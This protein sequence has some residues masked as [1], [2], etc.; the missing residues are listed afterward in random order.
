ML[1]ELKVK[2]YALIKNLVFR[3]G[4][5]FN[6]ITGETGAGKSVLLG[7][8]G[9]VLGER[10]DSVAL[11]ENEEKCVVEAW[12]DIRRYPLKSWFEQNEFD[13]SDELILRREIS[14][15]GKSRAF[16]N[17]TPAQLSQLKDLSKTL[18]DIHSQY[19]SL[20]LFQKSFQ[21]GVLDS[22]S[23]T[24][25]QLE[26]YQKQF[27]RYKELRLI[28]ADLKQKQSGG[29]S[30]RAFQEH[31]A[32]ELRTARV[33]EGEFEQ[34][35]EEQAALS[36]VEDTTHALEWVRQVLGTSEGSIVNQFALLRAQIAQAVRNDRRLEDLKERIESQY[37]EAKDL[38]HEADRLGA[39][40]QS[41][42]GRLDWVNQRLSLL[43]Q[44][45]QKH[46]TTDLS[47]KLREI[48]HSLDQYANMS[49]E[50]ESHEQ[51]LNEISA[52]CFKTAGEIA[53]ERKAHCQLLESKIN[54]M[55]SSLGMPGATIR[56]D[57][58][59]N[60]ELGTFGINDVNILFSP[61]RG[62]GFN[63]IQEIAS[64][65]E[66]SRVMLVLKVLLAEKNILPT[67]V[68]DEIDT[69]VSGEIALQMGKMLEEL[70]QRIQLL[71]I[72]HLPQI[73]SKGKRHFFV[74]KKQSSETTVTDITELSSESRVNEIAEMIGGK[75]YGPSILESARHLLN[76]Q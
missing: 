59:T 72:T 69:G 12:F 15:G 34:L 3:P 21:F 19:D 54:T 75:G 23:G 32:D 43:Y 74:F 16:I 71:V 24:D 44:L 5:S 18:I 13:Y 27:S 31:V 48:E 76:P 70:S 60:D 11:R 10:S 7:A 1:T 47:G 2:N 62:K 33:M 26:L 61:A 22:F 40:I 58:T 53:G 4:A 29:E 37:Q 30:E 25:K 68:F 9:L 41:D 55:I 51:K 38:E 42:P 6:V 46:K 36:A 8:L 67:I 63:P 73:A 14:T 57:L 66:I 50:I 35:E 28:L 65:G 39:V 64:G 49:S 17:D 56:I 45:R 20:D 52:L